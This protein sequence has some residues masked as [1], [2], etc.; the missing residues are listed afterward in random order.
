M[1]N[2]R[3]GCA[4]AALIAVPGSA[5]A[6]S[7]GSYEIDE[8][9]VTASKRVE[10][11]I[12]GETVAKSRASIGADFIQKQQPGQTI[13]ESLNLTPGYNF[14]NNDAYGNSGGNVRIRGFD[15]A[16]I[17]L[18]QDGIPLNDTGNYSIF[19]NQQVDPEL[20][21]RASVNTG[22]TDVDSPTASAAGGV[23][24]YIT[25]KPTKEP[26][27]IVQGSYGEENY[28]R[29]I[30]ILDSGEF[31]PWHT[32]AWVSG[33]YAK[34]DKFKGPGSEEKYQGNFRL[35]QPIGDSG[36]F[37]SVIGNYNVNRNNFV[38]NLRLTE[39]YTSHDIDRVD[40]C[41]RP[42]PGAGV[43]DERPNSGPNGANNQACQG[44]T[45]GANSGYYNL[46][47]N[48]SNTGNI[49]AQGRFTLADG[50]HFTVDPSF[51]YVLANGGGNEVIAETDPRLQG[52]FFNGATAATRI[53]RGVDLNGDGDIID[54]VRLYRP[55]NTNTHRYG[56]NS[57]LIWDVSDEHR[58]RV[59]YAFDYGRHRQT[60]EFGF[61]EAN[62][63]PQ[64]VFGGRN[65]TPVTT[66]DG[67][68]LQNRDRFSIAQLHQISGEY[69]GRFFEEKLELNIG[70]RAPFFRRE[71]NQ[72]C[73]TIAASN[74]TPGVAQASGSGF[75]FCTAAAEAQ[76]LAAGYKIVDF[77]TPNTGAAIGALRRPFQA[78]V[79]YN[80][81]LPNIGISFKPWDG[82][83]IY[84]SYAESLSAPRTDDL[85]DIQLSTVKPETTRAVD[86]GYRYQKGQILASGAIY[87][88]RFDNRIVRAFDQD[89]GINLVRNVGRVDFYGFDGQ[90]GFEPIKH[91][92]LYG[93]FSYTHTEVKSNFQSGVTS[94]ALGSLPIIVPTKGK[95]L[96]ETPKY[97]W[98]TRAEYN[99]RT[100]EIGLD[101]KHVGKRFATDVND[102]SVKGYNV[103]NLDA[104][105]K[106]D[107][108]LPGSYIQVNVI[109]L[110]DEKYLGSISSTT[111]VLAIPAT[112]TTGAV[113]AGGFP[114]YAVGAPQT[115]SVT[116]RVAF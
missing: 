28:R 52:S 7:T 24:N 87:Y 76:L 97:Q 25:R 49:R 79:K 116:L 69:R 91:V 3:L 63:D 80:K 93:T 43:Q 31:G 59:A 112:A 4:I 88:N 94:V 103:V 32:S 23:I 105:L 113:S 66:L 102:E 30:V 111:N 92:S 15:G 78:V 50:L 95:E 61:L 72:N 34:Y 20:I 77:G 84:A 86:L 26:G 68:P 51:Q 46:F 8:I 75:A 54:F 85:Y 60:G 41:I 70:V 110:F 83:Q 27:A 11:V 38:R 36:D 65:G 82:H 98:G 57:S 40:T 74:S 58:L 107:R 109:N 108:I 114:T 53:A 42:T 5:L 106:L 9:I 73:F 1:R 17:S 101:F 99:G 100:F 62:G 21:D 29:G 56:L 13:L 55:N 44:T 12:V 16:R 10:T 90:A 96:V 45:I 64:N 115:A 47:I 18:T 67:T 6:Q 35:Y 22:T 2:L 71:L 89:Q 33:S 19:S 37:V 48:P 39:Y 81:V 104:R 14:T